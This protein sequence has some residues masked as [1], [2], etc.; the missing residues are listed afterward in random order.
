M[1]LSADVLD[2]EGWKIAP[3]A[4]VSYAPMF[5]DKEATVYGVDQDVFSTNLVTGSSVQQLKKAHSPLKLR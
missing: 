2:Y 1:S 5:G 3:F 4:K